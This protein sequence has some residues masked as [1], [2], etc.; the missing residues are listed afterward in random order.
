MKSFLL[1]APLLP[2]V[3]AAVEAIA[4]PVS[5]RSLSAALS[6]EDRLALKIKAHHLV[7]GKYGLVQDEVVAQGLA[8]RG[9]IGT[10][11]LAGNDLSYYGTISLGTPPQNYEVVMDTGSAVFGACDNIT[12]LTTSSDQTG[13]LGLAWKKIA[14]SKAT[15]FVQALW[16]NNSLSNPV[17]GF[18]LRQLDA[19][20]VPDATSVESGGYLTIG[21]VNATLFS[22]TLNYVPL[23]N[24]GTYWNIPMDN[25]IVQG[26]T[27]NQNASAAVI[28][29]G[30]NSLAFPDEVAGAIYAAIPGSQAIPNSGGLYAYPC[31]TAVKFTLTFGG[32]DY[33]MLSKDFNGGAVNRAVMSFYSA[34]RFSPPSVG[35]ATIL[36]TKAL[37][38]DAIPTSSGD[39]TPRSPGREIIDTSTS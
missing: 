27:L 21:D 37:E 20:D 2:A 16:L 38:S 6:P 3:L 32:V 36:A 8:K 29:T 19:T 35:F 28:D 14:N 17:F 11:A 34:Y 24:S 15:P 23:S 7:K 22:G 1:V 30:T 13:L 9:A 31:S 26:K 10:E 4:V 33:P 39:N 25:I 12:S 5:R 18:G